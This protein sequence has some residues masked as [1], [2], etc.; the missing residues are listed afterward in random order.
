MVV[1]YLNKGTYSGYEV[2][3]HLVLSVALLISAIMFLM[4]VRKKVGH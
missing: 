3:L 4:D 1:Y 2:A